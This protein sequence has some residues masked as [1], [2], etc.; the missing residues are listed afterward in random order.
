MLLMAS[1]LWPFIDTK[2]PLI[3]DLSENLGLTEDS[4]RNRELQIAN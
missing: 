3:V 1:C 2:T 4:V